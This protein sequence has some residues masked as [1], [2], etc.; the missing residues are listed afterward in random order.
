MTTLLDKFYPSFLEE[1]NKSEINYQLAA[2]VIIDK[3]LVTKPCC[4]SGRNY[5]RRTVCGSVHAEANALLNFY[6]KNLQFDRKKNR[7]CLLWRK[8]KK[9]EKG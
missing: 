3:K 4:N 7:W 6:G 9:R 1:A 8:R 5:C 2:G